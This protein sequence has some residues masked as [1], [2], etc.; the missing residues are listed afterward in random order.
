MMKNARW[1][2]LA[3]LLLASCTRPTGPVEPAES[4]KV[5]RQL[6]SASAP[7][8]DAAEKR[9]SIT[10]RQVFGSDLSALLE[11]PKTPAAGRAAAVRVFAAT[12]GPGGLP[13]VIGGAVRND[14]DPA[15]KREALKAMVAYG[16]PAQKTDLLLL[17]AQEKDPELRN[18]IQKAIDDL[19]GRKRDWYAHRL[20]VSDNQDERILAAR[21]LGESGR[22][23]DVLLLE[24]TYATAGGALK[25]QIVLSIGKLG[26]NEA[27][28]FERRELDNNDAYVRA[29]AAIVEQTLKDPLAIPLLGAIVAKDP[30]G[31][32]RVSAMRALVAIG[33][34]EPLALVTA[35]C[36]QPPAPVVASVCKESIAALSGHGR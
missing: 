8:R 30:V 3:A 21:Y 27:L 34:P 2:A 35:G 13:G 20:Q 26:G 11:D 33:G 17:L 16:D 15:V 23:D 32:N 10:H 31:D 24:Q 9:L 14:P 25:Q 1:Y 5:V 6:A 22:A 12:A 19:D 28:E 7:T 4:A 36:K 29:A 18:D